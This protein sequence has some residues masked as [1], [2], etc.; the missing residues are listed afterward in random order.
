MLDIH[1]S[2]SLAHEIIT[3]LAEYEFLLYDLAELYRRPL[4]NLLWQLN[5]I[6]VPRS[7][8]L[9]VDKRWSH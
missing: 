4:D 5:V 6:F 1:K 3:F 9:R 7:S 2:S 8:L